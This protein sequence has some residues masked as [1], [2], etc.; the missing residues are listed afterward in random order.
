[1]LTVIFNRLPGGASPPSPPTGLSA[2][3]EP[4]TTP[5]N[6]DLFWTDIGDESGF[7]IE[8][9][10]DGINFVQIDQVGQ[11]SRSYVDQ[12]LSPNTTYYY[13]IRAFGPG[14]NSQYSNVA[15]AT[16]VTL[17]SLFAVDIDDAEAL[18]AEEEKRRRRKR[19]DE[20]M[21]L[22]TFGAAY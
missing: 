17:V 6:I 10:F 21:I 9:G 18:R 20:Q 15:F 14:G 8:R 7:F 3:D 11:S 19:R 13:R 4:T 22:A 12:N 5:L 1:M 2:Q 16:T